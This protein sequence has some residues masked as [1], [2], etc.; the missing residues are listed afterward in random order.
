MEVNR[1]GDGYILRYRIVVV[2]LGHNT[3]YGVHTSHPG[4]RSHIM[5]GPGISAVQLNS[6]FVLDGLTVFAQDAAD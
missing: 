5:H 3:L 1:L 4:S 2:V 6:S